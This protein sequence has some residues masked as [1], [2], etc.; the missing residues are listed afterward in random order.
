MEKKRHPGSHSEPEITLSQAK[1]I[2]SQYKIRKTR[3]GYKQTHNNC[4]NNHWLQVWRPRRCHINP[5]SSQCWTRSVQLVPIKDYLA[6]IGGT[7]KILIKGATKIVLWSNY[8]DHLKQ[9]CTYFFNKLRVKGNADQQ[10]LNTPKQ[11]TECT[12]EEVEPFTTPLP[13]LDKIST[14]KE[15]TAHILG[16][17]SINEYSS[18][19]HCI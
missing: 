4:T 16:V 1:K 5:I 18:C 19:C 8:A 9:G 11:Q 10:Y 7:K 3:C 14:S 13:R 2:Q 6:Y 17:S 12:I 15:I